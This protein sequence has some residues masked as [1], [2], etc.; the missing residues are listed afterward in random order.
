L[1][2][3]HLFTYG[4]LRP[5]H[6][7]DEIANVVR[8]LK[9]LG[10]GFVRG[11]LYDLG[12]YPGAVLDQSSSKRISGTVFRLPGDKTVLNKLDEYEEFFPDSPDTS[13]FIRR[14]HPVQLADGR[15]MRCWVYE[16]N[17]LPDRSAILKSGTYAR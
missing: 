10:K 12:S 9:P 17:G 13:L 16:Y 7:P 11:T 3:E 14:L 5:G 6:A 4:T 2:C 8:D 15:V 1:R